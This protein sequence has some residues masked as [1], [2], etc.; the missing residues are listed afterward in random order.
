M[1][2]LI[3]NEAFRRKLSVVRKLFAAEL[4]FIQE[5]SADLARTSL[6]DN[7]AKVFGYRLPYASETSAVR[8]PYASETSAVRHYSQCWLDDSIACLRKWFN[9]LLQLANS[10]PAEINRNPVEWTRGKVRDVVKKHFGL[11][12]R[13]GHP[14]LSVFEFWIRQSAGKGAVV[15]NRLRPGTLTQDSLPII[16]AEISQ[17][18]ERGLDYALQELTGFAILNDG[19]IPIIL[20]GRAPGVAAG[21]G[22]TEIERIRTADAGKKLTDP[23]RYPTMTHQEVAALCERSI[24]TVRNWV[25]KKKLRASGVAGRVTTQSVSELLFRLRKH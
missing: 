21:I 4:N 14:H 23:A 8:F 5:K 25:Y 3:Q 15:R 10:Y 17:K 24:K 1:A 7:K 16:A 2:K 22:N 12:K 11:G 9:E 20:D 6:E 13:L 19:A 18:F